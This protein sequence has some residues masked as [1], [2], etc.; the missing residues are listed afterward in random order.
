MQPIREPDSSIFSMA[1]AVIR[2]KLKTIGYEPRPSTIPIY[3]SYALARNFEICYNGSE[4]QLFRQKHSTNPI[5][6]N[7]H[8]S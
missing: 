1:R 7:E 6:E 8:D 2:F 3:N 5:V 4:L